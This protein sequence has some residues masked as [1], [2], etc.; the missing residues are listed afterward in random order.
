M[1][2]LLPLLFLL[3]AVTGTGV[4]LSRDPRRQVLAMAANGLA[5][6]LLFMA[7]QAPDVAF[8]EITVG[9]AALPL[10]FLVTLAS[11]RIDRHR[12]EMTR[13]IRIVLFALALLAL[14][15]AFWRIA[16]HMPEFGAHPLPY[17]D[18]INAVATKERHVTNMVSAINFDYRGFD[19]L[20]EEF[21]LLCAVTG[22]VVLLRGQRGEDMSAKPD[23]TGDRPVVDRSDSTILLARMIAPL[24]LLFGVY[25]MLHAMTTPGGGFQGG[26]IFGTGLML[27]WLG[28]GYSGW[29]RIARSRVLDAAEGGGAGLYALAGLAPM[30]LGLHF[31]ENILPLGKAG[32]MLSGGLMIV[33]NIGV[34]FA[35]AGGFGMLFVEFLE[36]TRLPKDNAE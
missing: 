28:E 3:V 6:G 35:V 26:V 31:L 29:R 9:T 27:V 25:V 8:S 30:L 24:T 4:V 2:V 36:E 11:I 23:R 33:V 13:R 20:G 16:A 12:E 17:G 21:M 18:A 34:G 19:T 7:L 10:L 1:R 15:P 32:D 22:A 5:L 14:A